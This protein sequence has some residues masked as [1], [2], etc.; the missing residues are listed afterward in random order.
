MS[1]SRKKG[2]SFSMRAGIKHFRLQV[3]IEKR[4]PPRSMWSI[5]KKQIVPEYQQFNDV[6]NIS[7][8]AE[9]I[10]KL[11]FLTR[12][13]SPVTSTNGSLF[14]DVNIC[15]ITVWYCMALFVSLFVLTVF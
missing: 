3:C 14:K 1:T 11:T 2:R 9:T 7:K 6:L 13:S 8:E 10:Q 12:Q 5:R 15:I 4:S